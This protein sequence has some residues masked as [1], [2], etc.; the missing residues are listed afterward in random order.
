MALGIYDLREIARR[1]EHVAPGD[2][3]PTAD[4]NQS[5]DLG[6]LCQEDARASCCVRDGGWPSDVWTIDWILGSMPRERHKW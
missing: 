4:V 2:M 6:V 5:R 1:I 3:A